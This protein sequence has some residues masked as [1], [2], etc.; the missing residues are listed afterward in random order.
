MATSTIPTDV[1]L[2][3]EDEEPVRRTVRDWLEHAGLGVRVLTAPDSAAALTMANE[4]SVDLAVLDWN[5]GAGLNGLDL[6]QDLHEFHPELVAIMMTAYAD[7]A[8]PLEAMRCGVRDYLDKNHE[9]TRD[10][11]L[12]A[13]RKQ[14]AYLRPAKR[15]R[16]LHHSLMEF[17]NNLEKILPLVRSISALNDPVTLPEV[18]GTLF[19]FLI[20]VTQAQDGVLFVRHYDASQE[21]QE[22]CRVYRATGEPLDEPLVPFPQSIAATAVSMQEPCLMTGLNRGNGAGTVQ[23]QPFEKGHTSLLAAPLAV[24]PG[25]HVVLELFD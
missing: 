11:F 6:L 25:L 20:N 5:L 10:T 12:A 2:V 9:L 23:L 3:V 21:P 15:E 13:V 18:I 8:T 22:T 7:K 4:N 19:R 14:L 24:A 1:V 16:Q 17:R